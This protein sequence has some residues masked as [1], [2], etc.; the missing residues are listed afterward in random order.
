MLLNCGVGEDSWES[1][2]LQGDKTSQSY[3]KSILNVHWKDCCWGW[4]S[5]TLATWWEELTHWKRRWCWE[6]LKAGR[7]GTD[8]GCDGWMASPPW[9]TWVWLSKLRE[10]VMDREAWHGAVHGVAESQTWLNN[11][12]ELNWTDVYQQ[13]D[14]SVFNMPSRFV[15]AFLLRSKHLL[16]SLLQS[17]SI[18][19]LESKKIKSVTVS[20]F[21]HLFAMKQWDI[22]LYSLRTQFWTSPLFHVWF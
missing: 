9:C 8:R 11:P 1:I 21:S 16:I 18:V 20:T 17:L 19:I 3:R 14:V 12:T 15:I 22:M 4:N 2:G 7:E 13:S 6:R 5:N 10:L